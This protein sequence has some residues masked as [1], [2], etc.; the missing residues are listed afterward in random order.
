MVNLIKLFSDL[1]LA[2]FCS[3]KK[4]FKTILSVQI[5]YARSRVYLT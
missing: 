5:I 1:Y 3:I 2:K 4:Y